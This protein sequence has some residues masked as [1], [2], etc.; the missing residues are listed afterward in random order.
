MSIATP[1]K[2]YPNCFFGLKMYHLA[3]LVEMPFLSNREGR[4]FFITSQ[5]K[6]LRGAISPNVNKWH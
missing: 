2:I 5:A 3:T 6:L 4:A 1:S